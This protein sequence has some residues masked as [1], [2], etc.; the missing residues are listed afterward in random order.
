[1][2]EFYRASTGRLRVGGKLLLGMAL[3]CAI[4]IFLVPLIRK[5]VPGDEGGLS[6]IFLYAAIGLFP[7]GA[8][9]LW[10]GQCLELKRGKG[11]AALAIL[12][13]LAA[14]CAVR[15]WSGPDGVLPSLGVAL[16]AAVL[17]AFGPAPS[18]A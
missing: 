9:L 15:V 12:A 6:P 3:L 1:M 10:L 8:A 13:G 4:L 5:P 17:A 11:R 14:F 2:R 16:L 18:T 7:V